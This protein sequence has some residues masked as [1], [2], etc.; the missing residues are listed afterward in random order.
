[1]EALQAA[2]AK[3]QSH[4]ST[5]KKLQS[6]ADD[7]AGMVQVNQL[8]AQISASTQY[9]TNGNAASAN[10]KLEEQAMTDATNTLQSA[11]T[12]PCRRT[13]R[14]CLR[15]SAR[16]SPRSCSSSLQDLVVHRQP[17]GQQRQLPVLRHRERPPRPS[18]KSAASS[19]IPAPIS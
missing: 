18:P 19:A 3:T 8:N 11:A 6:A 9:V 17:A 14:R 5:G 1:M 4:L 13:T 16:T 2:M 7:P 12:S 15:R 10:L